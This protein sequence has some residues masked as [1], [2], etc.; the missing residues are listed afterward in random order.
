VETTVKDEQGLA[1]MAITTITVES[2]QTEPETPATKAPGTPTLSHNNG[3]VNG[4]L[5]GDYTVSMNMWW[6]ENATSYKLYEDGVLVDSQKLTYNAPWAQFAQTKIKGKTNGTYTY[7]AELA[8]DK[9]VTRSQMLTVRVTAALPGKAVLSHD[10]WDMDG[11][12]KVMMNLWWG[13]NATA[14]RL[15][16]NDELIDT[17]SLK[18]TTPLPQFAITAVKGKASGTYAYRAE[19]VNAAGVT[20]TNTI[21]VK[22]K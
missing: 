8:N 5:G 16:E 17:Q 12:Y 19:L 22:V 18:A 20:T 6:G 10:N 3:F 11:N 2:A 13:T 14:Y 4:L 1:G 9:G 7:V 21:T 15:Y